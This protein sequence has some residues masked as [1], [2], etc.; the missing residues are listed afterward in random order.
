MTTRTL[1]TIE[2]PVEFNLAAILVQNSVAVISR[3][4]ELPAGEEIFR[5]TMRRSP[6]HI[7]VG[8]LTD[9]AQRVDEFLAS[10]EAPANKS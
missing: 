2:E 5:S 3:Q 8:E 6:L 9:D 7:Y 10:I 1:V 4:G